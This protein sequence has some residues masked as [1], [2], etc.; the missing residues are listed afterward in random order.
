M[1]ASRDLKLTEGRVL[2]AIAA[3]ANS[4]TGNAWPS[5]ETIAQYVGKSERTVQRA[6]AKLLGAGRLVRERVAALG[7]WVY[8]I[9]TGVTDSRPGGDKTGPG[10]DKNAVGGD[11]HG[12]SPEVDEE[13][14]EG[15]KRAGPRA[16]PPRRCPRHVNTEAGPPCGGCAAA[17][18]DHDAWLAEQRHAEQRRRSAEASQAA[19]ASRAAIDACGLCDRHGYLPGTSRCCG[20]DPA[21]VGAEGHEADALFARIGLRRRG[22]RA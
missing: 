4:K 12:M 22:V 2:V 9:V 15:E 16:E 8:R 18:R 3:H 20:H 6:I 1:L 19:A 14:L 11:T 5:V 10:G 21:R 13:G 17:R 7:R